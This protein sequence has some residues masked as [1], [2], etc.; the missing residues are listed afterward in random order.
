MAVPRSRILVSTFLFALCLGLLSGCIRQPPKPVRS[1]LQIRE[2]QTR[3][4]QTDDTTIVM[5]AVLNAI[6]DD[7]FIVKNAESQLGLLTA[8]KEVD[9]A[10]NNGWDGFLRNAL[11]DDG[12]RWAKTQSTEAN[13]TI[14]PFGGRVR[15][16]ITFQDKVIDNRGGTLE[17]REIEDPLFYQNFFARIE[18]SIFLQQQKI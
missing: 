3:E 11:S 18:H 4:F 15:V 16:R 8:S 7:G 9:L 6:Q 12:D 1:T 14:A 2:L 13:A 10:P 17:V 5:R